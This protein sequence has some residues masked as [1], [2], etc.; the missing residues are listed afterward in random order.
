MDVICGTCF[1]GAAGI[2]GDAAAMAYI[3]DA[4]A[5]KNA[6]AHWKIGRSSRAGDLF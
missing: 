3:G 1:V 5:K 6:A 4:P 2:G